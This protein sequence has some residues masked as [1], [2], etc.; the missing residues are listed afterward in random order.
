MQG[1]IIK[2]MYVS[3]KYKELAVF[4]GCTDILLIHY[5]DINLDMDHVSDDDIED[6]QSDFKYY[7]DILGGMIEDGLL[8]DEQIDKFNLQYLAESRNQDDD[9]DEDFPGKRVADIA[10]LK[11][12]VRDQFANSPNPY[13]EKQRIVR[14]PA[15]KVDK[16]AYT[17]AM[18]QSKYNDRKCFCQMCQ[19]LVSKKYIERNDVQRE[20]KY[21]WSQMY[22]SMCLTCSKDFVLLRNN[23]AVWERF[24]QEIKDA[25][26]ENRSNAEIEIGDRTIAFTAT[27]LAEIQEI[28]AIKAD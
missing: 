22:L 16:E 11:K 1:E 21:G 9:F 24:I 10:R 15:H 6:I 12:H 17:V 14:E 19:R 2:E 5:S 25:N 27:H 7:A 13:V 26:V 3:D 8:T 20:P 28:L 4:L 23:R 18:Y